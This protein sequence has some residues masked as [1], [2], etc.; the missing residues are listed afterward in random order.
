MQKTKDETLKLLNEGKTSEDIQAG[1]RVFMLTILIDIRDN[2]QAQNIN[3][4]RIANELEFIS[5]NI[6]R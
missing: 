5:S 6:G 3:F 1:S 4:E 2:L